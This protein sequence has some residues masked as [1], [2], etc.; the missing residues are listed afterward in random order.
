MSV[1]SCAQCVIEQSLRPAENV[2]ECKAVFV[3]LVRT[4]TR[5]LHV[6]WTCCQSLARR[7]ATAGPNC[8]IDGEIYVS[9]CN[10]MTDASADI[11]H[12]NLST[13]C[14]THMTRSDFVCRSKADDG[15]GLVVLPGSAD[16]LKGMLSVGTWTS[17]SYFTPHGDLLGRL[18]PKCPIRCQGRHYT[19][20][21]PVQSICPDVNNVNKSRYLA[22]EW[23]ESWY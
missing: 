2:I 13:C 20:L 23:I 9:L 16:S 6:M 22:V 15:N 4:N 7:T 8:S 17:C 5:W 12:C 11:W 3:C 21:K 19:V 18:P 10:T 14:Q 1:T